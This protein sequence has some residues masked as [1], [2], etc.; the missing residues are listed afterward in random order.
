MGGKPTAPSDHSLLRERLPL[1]GEMMSHA[2]GVV[3]GG[4]TAA[5]EKEK[6]H[7]DKAEFGEEV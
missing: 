4:Q 7:R 1:S 6:R 2:A 3:G 5:G